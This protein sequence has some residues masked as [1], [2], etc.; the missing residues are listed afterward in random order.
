MF[1][2]PA[3]PALSRAPLRYVAPFDANLDTFL[4]H[5]YLLNWN[6][7]DHIYYSIA[8]PVVIEARLILF[9]G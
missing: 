6:S 7:I 2:Q 5:P 4:H 1:S 3:L 8:P 9:D